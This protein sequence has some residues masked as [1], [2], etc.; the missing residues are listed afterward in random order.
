LPI[1]IEEQA[2]Q[3]SIQVIVVGDVPPST[4][5]RVELIDWAPNPG[6]QS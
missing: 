1:P 6:S 5:S 3:P 4:R 2:V